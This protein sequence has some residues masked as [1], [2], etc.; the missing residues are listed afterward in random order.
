MGSS[1][2]P[3]L[4]RW[5]GCAI[6]VIMLIE[7]GACAAADHPPSVAA[8]TADNSP[9]VV[10]GAPK[11]SRTAHPVAPKRSG[12]ALP[13]AQKSSETIQP[14]AP[15]N[16]ARSKPSVAKKPSGV[17]PP[18]HIVVVIFENEHRSNV[19]GNPRAPYLNKLAGQGANMTHSYGITHPSQ[20]NYLALFSGTT[21]GV[22]SNAC[23][24]AVQEETEPGIPAAPGGT[25][26]HRLRRGFTQD[27]LYRMCPGSLPAQA[28]SVGQFR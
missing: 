15:K 14:V 7:L 27:G 17:V 2:L 1:Q 19:I 26:L 8:G 28:Q 3:A 10:P 20:P 16:P 21:H 24:R 9:T 11:G 13:E 23:L 12:T 18:D 6:T 25:Q 5:F 4:R 22:S